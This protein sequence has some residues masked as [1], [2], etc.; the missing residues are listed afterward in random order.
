VLRPQQQTREESLQV[1]PVF[2]PAQGQVQVFQPVVPVVPVFQPAQ[3]QV[4]HPAQ[5]QVFQPVVQVFQ[6]VVQRQPGVQVHVCHL[7]AN[8]QNPPKLRVILRQL[9]LVLELPCFFAA[10]KVFEL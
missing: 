9:E 4:F 3:G 8:L 1:V 5:G 7:E 6:P 2:Q 10:Q